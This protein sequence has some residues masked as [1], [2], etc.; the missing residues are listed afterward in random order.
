MPSWDLFRNLKSTFGFKKTAGIPLFDPF[1]LFN[2]F[3]PFNPF[4]TPSD[5]V[6]LFQP[7]TTFEDLIRMM[8]DSDL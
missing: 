8:V 1:N 4:S 7:R 5:S 6:A 3:N 2:L